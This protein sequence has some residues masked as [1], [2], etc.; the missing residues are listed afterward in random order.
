MSNREERR[1]AGPYPHVERATFEAVAGEIATAF[2][3]VDAVYLFGS[4]A[5]GRT[6]PGSDADLAVLARTGE[7]PEDHIRVEQGIAYF[8]E[9]RLGLPVDVV[10]IRRELSPGLLFDMFRVETILFARDRERAHR[11]ACQARAEYRDLRPRLDRIF[12]RVRRQIKEHADALR[13]A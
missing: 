1:R 11:V 8:A 12:A 3:W 9:D 10:L 13:R 5:R 2:P 7:A 4:R 6:H